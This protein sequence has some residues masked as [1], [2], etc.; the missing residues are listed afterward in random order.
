M[1]TLQRPARSCKEC[2]RR[3]VRCDAQQPKC[4][5]CQ[6]A[7]VPCEVSP[8][9]KRGPKR[10]HLNAL[11]NR[12]M[13]LE[14]TLQNRLNS[15]QRPQE[16]TQGLYHS[17]DSTDASQS[18]DFMTGDVG[19]VDP[20]PQAFMFS[21]PSM[22]GDS[23]ALGLE[24]F[25]FSDLALSLPQI[26][27][28]THAELDQLYFDRVHPSFP[29]L[30]K[31]R[32]LG[33]SKS[34][35]KSPSQTCLQQVMWILA[36]LLSTQSRDLINPL[37]SRVRQDIDPIIMD[38]GPCQLELVQAWTLLTV[39]ELM[40]ALY[41]QAWA[42]AGRMFRLLQGLRYHEIDSPSKDPVA[43]EGIID[44]I[45]TEEKRRVFWMAFF[46]DHLLSIRNR[47]PICTRL[48]ISDPAFQA[49]QLDSS[50]FLSQAVT[51][52]PSPDTC[53]FN[54]CIII[55]T[56]SGRGL[57]HDVHGTIS[58][59]YGG[60]GQI[61]IDHGDWMNLV[62]ATRNQALRQRNDNDRLGTFA[63]ILGQVTEVLF[64][65]SLMTMNKDSS[66]EICVQEYRCRALRATEKIVRFAK[67]LTALHFSM[68]HPFMFI[69]LFVTAEFLYE[70]RALGGAFLTQ[71]R[72]LVSVFGQLTNVNDHERSYLD[73]LS[74]SCI[75][76]S[77]GVLE[78][79]AQQ[80]EDHLGQPGL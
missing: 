68:V 66:N 63:Q 56:L 16:H 33:W 46:I 2:Q 28:R 5:L 17:L 54:E 1:S 62:L 72:S 60:S 23:D 11:R 70:N 57:L 35:A 79:S 21:G 75:S 8:A 6:R 36:I 61:H 29:I 71:L 38:T 39:C 42:S 73:L 18:A 49:A 9:G 26:D 31:R 44:P 43:S 74:R 78:Q 69:P 15:E 41:G 77:R 67:D 24:T 58:R 27:R 48:P 25:P 37:Y 65:K 59:A 52:P 14:E 50:V 64:C 13:Q 10:G 40:R 3:K 45:R 19:Y 53:S 22:D 51:E 55:A 20:L 32:Y 34:T 4:G 12:L 30:H 80:R 47:W 7:R 76:S